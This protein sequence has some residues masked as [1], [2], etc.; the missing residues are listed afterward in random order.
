MRRLL[1]VSRVS[2]YPE[3]G[4]RISQILT[5]MAETSAVSVRFLSGALSAKKVNS[6]H[7]TEEG[8]RGPR[9]LGTRAGFSRIGAG[10]RVRDRADSRSLQ[11]EHGFGSATSPS[12]SRRV[13][14]RRSL[15]HR[16]RTCIDRKRPTLSRRPAEHRTYQRS[17]H[18]KKWRVRGSYLP[19]RLRGWTVRKRPLL[20]RKN[21]RIPTKL[22]HAGNRHQFDGRV[23]TRIRSPRVGVPSRPLATK[24][25]SPV[26][27]ATRIGVRDCS[28]FRGVLVMAADP[29]LGLVALVLRFRSS[30]RER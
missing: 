17:G 13:S 3:E 20:K 7:S 18:S 28:C 30:A 21:K 6:R 29:R 9:P 16:V 19:S 5:R 10:S 27:I 2:R 12:Q 23:R 25:A 11:C 14:K 26:L 22:A 1:V 4:E 8:S 24:A 15:C